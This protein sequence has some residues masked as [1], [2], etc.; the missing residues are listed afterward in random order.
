MA[1][2]PEKAGQTP[3]TV[4]TRVVPEIQM[5]NQQRRGRG[6]RFGGCYCCSQMGHWSRDRPHHGMLQVP[7][8]C[9]KQRPFTQL[10]QG[11]FP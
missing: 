3:P 1:I 4:Q 6:F 9:T 8:H 5:Q 7:E 10:L 2:E 11:R